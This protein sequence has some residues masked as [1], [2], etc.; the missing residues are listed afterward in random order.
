MTKANPQSS[1]Q[2]RPDLDDDDMLPEYTFTGNGVRGKYYQAIQKHGYSV[3]VHHEDGTATTRHVSPQEVMEQNRQRELLKTFNQP[4]AQAHTWSGDRIQ[5][6]KIGG[7]KIGGDKVMGNKVQIDTV[8][9]DAVAGNKTVN[10]QD[11]TQAAQD[12]K[13]LLDQLATDYPNESPYV[14]AGR[15]ID[16]IKQNPTLTQRLG[17]ALQASGTAAVETAIA[18]VTDNPAVSVII[19]G[20]K[21]FIKTEG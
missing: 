14:Q 7:D 6:D 1:A 17:N 21:G 4:T 16:T 11:L 13:A 18:A 3:T 20:V 5:G 19:A 2:D 9:G 8:Q 12:I 10:A 15:A